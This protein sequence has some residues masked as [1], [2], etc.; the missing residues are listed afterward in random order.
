M[1]KVR[2]EMDKGKARQGN[3]E[4]RMAGYNGVTGVMGC[5]RVK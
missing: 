2:D 1:S 5:D 4:K 3:K